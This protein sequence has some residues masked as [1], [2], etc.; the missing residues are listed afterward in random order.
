MAIKN[1][2]AG[3]L[4]DE[5]DKTERNNHEKEKEEKENGLEKC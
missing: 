3:K 2:R 5:N 4:E 1:P